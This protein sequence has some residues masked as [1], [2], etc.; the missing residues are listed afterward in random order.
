M[1]RKGTCHILHHTLSQ[2]APTAAAALGITRGA[3]ESFSTEVSADG[4]VEVLYTRIYH[5]RASTM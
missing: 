4:T 1:A 2:L 3:D 5:A